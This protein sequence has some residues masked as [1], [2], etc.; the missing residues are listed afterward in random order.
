VSRLEPPPVVGEELWVRV[1]TRWRFGRVVKVNRRRV[2]VKLGRPIAGHG[3]RILFPLVAWNY[4]GASGHT[5]SR[6]RPD[7]EIGAEWQP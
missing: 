2:E 3:G 6:V 5:I 7:V 1:R 4:D